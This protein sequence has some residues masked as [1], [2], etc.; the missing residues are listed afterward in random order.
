MTDRITQLVYS[1]L[2]IFSLVVTSHAQDMGKWCE[3]DDPAH[4]LNTDTCPEVTNN[5]DLPQQIVLPMPCGR[6]M[7]FK[8]V[9]IQTDHLLD[10]QQVF[11][12]EFH[13]VDIATSEPES[14]YPLLRSGPRNAYISG[15][16]TQ[17]GRPGK[18]VNERSLSQNRERAYYIAKYELTMPQYLLF[19]KGLLN[20]QI[21]ISTKNE[22]RCSQYN[23]ELKKM[24]WNEKRG[25]WNVLPATNL[26][27]FDAVEFS[28]A[29][30]NWLIALDQ[31][32][33]HE[34][35]IPVLPWEQGSTGY[36]RLPTETEWEFAARSG[37]A[38]EK[39]ERNRK[40]YMIEDPDTGKKRY[41]KIT[42]IAYQ[43]RGKRLELS[44]GD[45]LPNLLG[46]YDMVGNVE[47]ITLDTFRLSATE[48]HSQGQ[49]GGY[50]LKG[51]NALDE[52][53]GVGSRSESPFYNQNGETRSSLAGTRMMI[54]AP[55]M[56]EGWKNWKTTG[57]TIRAK[58]M[59]ISRQKMT[60]PADEHRRALQDDLDQFKAQSEKEKQ[61]LKNQIAK[62][63][64][65]VDTN[66]DQKFRE[67][68]TMARASEERYAEQMAQMQ[69]ALDKSNYELN[70]R[71]QQIA[72]EQTRNT[73]LISEIILLEGREI[74]SHM[75]TLF[76]AE[77]FREKSLGQIKKEL[78]LKEISPS[79]CKM[80]KKDINKQYDKR[81]NVIRSKAQEKV[82]T[83]CSLF[84]LYFSNLS[85]MCNIK[86]EYVKTALSKLSK[87]ESNQTYNISNQTLNRTSKHYDAL[88]K[89]RGEISV[90]MRA[91][92]AKQLDYRSELDKKIKR[93]PVVK[94][95]LKDIECL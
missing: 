89:N 52:N 66:R 51:G 42:E 81:S 72:F 88:M 67:L 76:L 23:K 79:E 28:R 13:D 75:K 20:I 38:G 11:L 21:P 58:A 92:W 12:G 63:R 50:I 10:D 56:T 14:L 36:I 70:K 17:A 8:K 57:N 80:K 49:V 71:N 6:K 65:S 31:Q 93:H 24:A 25:F 27:W 73:A 59:G 55:V 94:R 26:S 53:I 82:K 7:V 30:S 19:K 62:L 5:Q 46:L 35:K 84:P 78:D 86:K 9:L 22:N 18:S 33:I 91:E 87:N 61:K 45:Y 37:M 15:G 69:A 41:G 29:Y 77:K 16:F 90:K 60:A 4:Y 1:F 44:I 47:E 40:S 54:S 74:A 2:F 64:Q 83:Y 34:G 32:R 43:T 85:S 95:F 3:L 39:A 68:E 48:T